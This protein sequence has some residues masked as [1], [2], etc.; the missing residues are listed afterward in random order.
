MQLQFRQGKVVGDAT[1]DGFSVD[2]SVVYL[3]STCWGIRH[4][5]KRI[6]ACDVDVQ[7]SVRSEI[8]DAI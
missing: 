2:E 1:A 5:E 4:I 8:G 3:H 7:Q 6:D